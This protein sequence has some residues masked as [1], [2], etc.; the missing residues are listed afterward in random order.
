[1]KKLN[2]L[3]VI[4]TMITTDGYRRILEGLP[5][6]KIINWNSIAQLLGGINREVLTNKHTIHGIL[7]SA[8]IVAQLCPNVSR[9]YLCII[10]DIDATHLFLLSDLITLTIYGAEIFSV[11]RSLN[12]FQF[13]GRKL[14]VLKFDYV[15]DLN[16]CPIFDYCV[17]LRD[18]SVSYSKFTKDELNISPNMEHF[19]SLLQLK[20]KINEDDHRMAGVVKFYTNLKT[21]L[22]DCVEAFND[23]YFADAFQSGG[24]RRIEAFF[25]RR[26]GN[27]SVTTVQLMMRNCRELTL[28]GYMR[29]WSAIKPEDVAHIEHEIRSN[30]YNMNLL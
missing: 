12:I 8:E 22:A 5:N 10:A 19:K 25:L 28:L 3:D 24:F 30:R 2:M 7:D 14:Q 21:L 4:S 13:I 26:C 9:L 23:E 17:C 29:T 15:K 20:L 1:M 11:H 18:L 16:M 27:L 6:I